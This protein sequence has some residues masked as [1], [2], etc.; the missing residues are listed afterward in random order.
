MTCQT[1]GLDGHNSRTCSGA[2]ETCPNCFKPTA[3]MRDYSQRHDPMYCS[4][5]TSPSCWD[6][7]AAEEA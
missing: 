3:D 5:I 1:C 6:W 2:H 7:E 4:P